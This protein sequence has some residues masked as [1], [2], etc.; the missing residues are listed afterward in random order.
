MFYR[1]KKALAKKLGRYGLGKSSLVVALAIFGKMTASSEAAAANVSVTTASLKVG[2]AASLAVTA[3]SKTTLI[4]LIAAGIVGGTSA[5]VVSSINENQAVRAQAREFARAQQHVGAASANL[6]QCWYFF[7]EGPGKPLMMRLMGNGHPEGDLACRYL[8]NGHATYFFDD[9][10]V[11]L[12]NHRFYNPDLSVRR[13]PT[14]QRRLSEF[15][16]QVEGTAGDMEYVSDSRKGLLVI[17]KRAEAENSRIW[18]V[19]QHRTVLEEQCFQSDWP[20][21]ARIE[22]NRDAMHKRGWTYFTVSGRINNRKISGTGRIPF[23]YEASRVHYPWFDIKVGEGLRIVDAGAEAGVYDGKGNAIARYEGGRLFEGFPRPWMGL[24]AI[25]TVRRD[26]ARR[27]VWFQ[28]K[29]RDQSGKVN[30]EIS[31][32]SLKLVYEIDLATDVIDRITFF[33]KNNG[34]QDAKGEVRFSYLM[35]IPPT[36]DDFA[37]PRPTSSATRRWDRLGNF[38]LVNLASGQW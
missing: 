8:Q 10:T 7:P 12:S 13:L 5:A 19:D 17:L 15:I 24:H 36:S 9:N 35:E 14:D 26:A 1:A 28:T 32:E 2:L 23:V 20:G 33:E 27:G 16:S 3:A 6:Q 25:D 37:A 29:Q 34:D 18:R 38:W 22:D 11:R 21:S 31:F 4:T 30:V